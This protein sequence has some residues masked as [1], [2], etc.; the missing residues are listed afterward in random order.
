MIMMN[1]RFRKATWY[2]ASWARVNLRASSSEASHPDD[3]EI[4]E[5][6]LKLDQR[7][8]ESNLVIVDEIWPPPQNTFCPSFPMV[9]REASAQLLL[10]QVGTG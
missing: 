4:G 3:V 8:A 2:L 7:F 10:T 5:I 1:W 9:S 6:A